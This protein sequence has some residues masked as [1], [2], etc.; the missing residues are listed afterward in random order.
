MKKRKKEAIKRAFFKKKLR[1]ENEKENWIYSNFKLSLKYFKESR[2]YILFALFLFFVSTAFGYVFPNLFEK[3][4]LKIIEEIIKQTEGLGALEL[5]RFIIFNNLKS[6][7]L[8]LISGVLLG[9]IPFFIVVINGYVLGFVMEKS[10]STEGVLI[11][12]RLF[13]H[14]IFEIPAVIISIG[15]GLKLGMFLFYKRRKKKEFWR[16]IN[17]S[18]KVFL[19]VVIPLLVI[20]G[21]IEGLL[22]WFIG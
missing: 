14:G 11:L 7:F 5:V 8:G 1:K 22:I 21:I 2:N 18:F 19:L 10:V 6:S 17:N 9:I 13:P 16:W 12:W 4:V 15:L 3:Q 20:A